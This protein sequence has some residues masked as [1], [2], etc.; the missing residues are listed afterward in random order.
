MEGFAEK[1]LL[2]FGFKLQSLQLGTPKDVHTSAEGAGQGCRL[3][4]KPNP[5]TL[6]YSLFLTR[7]ETEAHRE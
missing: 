4:G 2:S 7:G 6:S 1:D 3:S 5:I